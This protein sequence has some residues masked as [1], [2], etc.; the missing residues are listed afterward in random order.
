M[1]PENTRIVAAINAVAVVVTAL[2]LAFRSSVGPG[3]TVMAV[4]AGVSAL[5]LARE[6]SRK[7]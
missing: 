2:L 1:R 5:I 7:R 4:I 6:A 3:L